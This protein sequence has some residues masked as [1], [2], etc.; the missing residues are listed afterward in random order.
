MPDGT[1]IT[2]AQLSKDVEDFAEKLTDDRGLFALLC[3]GSY[4]QY[5]AYLGALNAGCPVFLMFENQSLEACN[6]A[7]KYTFSAKENVLKRIGGDTIDY[8][9][10]LAVL[11]STSGST[12]AAKW[13]RLSFANLAANSSSIA[14]YLSLTESDRAPL[15]LPFQYSYGMS[16]VNS[17]LATGA[18]LVLTQGSVVDKAFWRTFETTGC[19]SFAGVPHSYELMDQAQVSTNHLHHLRYMT[20]AGGRLD[21]QRV[22]SWVKRGQEEGWDFF[23][24]YGQTEASPRISYLPPSMALETPSSIGIPVSGGEMWVVDEEGMRLPDGEQGELCYRGP[25]T[26][27]GYAIENADLLKPQ[28]TDILK[29]GDVAQRLSNGAF[30]IVGRMSRFVKLFGLRI[31]LD[32]IE[33]HLAKEGIEAACVARNDMMHL[34]VAG[35]TQNRSRTIASDLA[36][37]LDVPATSFRVIPVEVLPRHSSG[38]IDLRAV[39]TLV[40]EMTKQ[41]DA[42]SKVRP[43]SER[44]NVADIFSRYFPEDQVSL[45]ASFNSLGGNSLSYVSVSLELE[46]VLGHL[47]SEWARMTIAQLQGEAGEA[48][49]FIP[50]DTPTLSGAPPLPSGTRNMN[51]PDLSFWQLVREDFR[52][53]DASIFHQGFLMLFVHR[54]GNWRMGVRPRLLRP[55]LTLIYRFLNKLTEL[56]FGMKL[57]YTVKVG[58]RVKLEHFGGMILGA[59]EIKDDVVLRQ[60]TTLGIRTRADLNA[61]PVLGHRVDVGAGAVIVGNISIGDNS[62]IGANSVVFSN[63]PANSVVMGVPAKVICTNPDRNP[64]PLPD[65]DAI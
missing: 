64:S 36:Q 4:R 17:H 11:L 44:G 38:K 30:E 14:E 48:R 9:P 55:P 21:A 5:V 2:Y 65:Y 57:C 13:V 59:R 23:V 45:D 54:F 42:E 58:R 12:G 27:M 35:A 52:T 29:T 1:S 46:S 37:W 18:S 34:A 28:G 47:P 31:S 26:M 19:T 15:A 62:I 63:I 50:M 43:K 40:E 53:N 22:E 20:Q 10:D 61:K 39:G 6:I 56:L 24:M 41:L 32:E 60:N 25:N 51:P 49:L 16:I 3:D 7:L 8:H 33:K